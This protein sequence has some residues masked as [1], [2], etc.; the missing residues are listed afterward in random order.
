[1]TETDLFLKEKELENSKE[2]VE[3]NIRKYN[4]VILP[5]YKSQG[6]TNQFLGVNDIP[7]SCR[8]FENSKA[9]VKIL[10]CTGYNESYLK[11][12]ELI[13]NLFEMGFSVYC[14]DHRGQGFSGRF[15]GQE[16]KGYVDHFENYVEDLSFYF[17]NIVN[18]H[19]VELP[20]FILAHSMGG[21]IA[22]LAVCGK[23]ITP[24]GVILSSP[25]HAIALSPYLILEY[26]IYSLT[27]IFCKLGK[28]K[29]YVFGQTDCIPFRPFEGNDVTN[30][31]FRYEIWRKH[32]SEIDDMQLGGPTFGWMREAIKASRSARK[33]GYDNNVPI[34]VLQAEKDSVVVNSA[35]DIFIKSCANSEK[36]FLENAQHE[37]LMEINPIRNKAIEQI[38]I[39]IHKK[40]ER[41]KI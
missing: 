27:N 28:N 36:F 3:E 40:I 20:T 8:I 33:M 11:Y 29:E 24:Y 26:L 21:A 32:I 14:F 15:I 30:S 9:T 12:A 18:G 10:L 2:N 16:K 4:E 17:E 37:I 34:L 31:K 38:K 1:M 5:F 25:M 7:I 23:K 41:K 35:H 13:M 39:F 19:Q 6:S 22:T